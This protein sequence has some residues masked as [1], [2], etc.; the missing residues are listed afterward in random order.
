M[1][2]FLF[3]APPFFS[4]MFLLIFGLVIYN[5]IRAGVN[6][7]QNATSPILT[8]KAKVLSKRYQVDRHTHHHG[9]HVH[10]G[11]STSYYA[12][13]ELE[14][15]ERMELVMNGRQYGLLLEG[16]KGLLTYQGEWYKAFD[17]EK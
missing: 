11:S 1:F 17:R 14:N 4:L 3:D 5:L 16:D 12:T 13:F 9:N 2:N 6:Y 10:H 15:G 7:V 8:V